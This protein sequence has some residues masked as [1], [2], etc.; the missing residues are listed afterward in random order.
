MN[1]IQFLES[2]VHAARHALRALRH[3]PT[4]ASV[5]VLPLAFGIGANTAIF[6]VVNGVLIKPLAYPQPNRLVAVW[7]GSRRGHRARFPLFALD[8]FHLS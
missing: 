7:C 1:T 6:S 5:A 2:L 4:F 8:V 3:N